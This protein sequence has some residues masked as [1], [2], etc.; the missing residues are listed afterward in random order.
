MQVKEFKLNN[1][2]FLFRDKIRDLL[3]NCMVQA[4]LKG[5]QFKIKIDKDVPK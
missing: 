1:K 4:G 2:I 5:L 3:D